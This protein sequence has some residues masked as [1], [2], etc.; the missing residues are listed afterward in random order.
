MPLS[1][2]QLF[3]FN[4]AL[5]ADYDDAKAHGDLEKYGD[6]FRFQL[7]AALHLDRCVDRLQDP[8]SAASREL[9]EKELRAWVTALQS[10][11]A[12]LRQGYYLPD[13]ANYEEVVGDR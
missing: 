12:F 5:L 9:D 7:I 1:D 3:D 8:E 10:V 4:A 2:A 6:A 11:A 13:G